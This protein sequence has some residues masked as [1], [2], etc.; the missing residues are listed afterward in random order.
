MSSRTILL[1]GVTGFLGKV[2]LEELMR[3][4]EEIGLDRVYAVIRPR[5]SV[6]A[7]RRFHREVERSPCFARLPAGWARLVT[8][9]EGSLGTPGLS[10]APEMRDELTERVT[11]AL[12][13]AATVS[14]GLPVAEAAQANVA[15]TL[16]L[17]E[18]AKQCRC[19]ERL[20][21]VSTAYVTPHTGDR[22]PVAPQPVPLPEP[23]DVLYEGICNGTASEEALLSA[24]GLPN[25]YTLTKLLAEHLTLARRGRVPLT[26]L[27]PSI[28]SASWRLPFPGWID[29]ATGFGAFVVQLGLGRMRA[30][31]GRAGAR[32]DLIPVDEVAHAVIAACDDGPAPV[33]IRQVVAGIDRSPTLWQC[34]EGIRD[35]FRLH[36]VDRRPT[37]RYLGPRG[38]GFAIAEA[39]HHRLATR[40]RGRRSP[41]ARRAAGQARARL[42]SLNRMFP[43]FTTNSFAFTEPT[44]LPGDFDPQTYVTRVCRGVHRHLLDG[45]EREWPLAGR[46]HPGHGGDFRWSLTRDRGNAWIRMASWVVTKVLRRSIERVTVDIPSFEAAIRAAPPGSALAVLPNHR[47]Y[48]D[49]VLCSYLCFARPDLGIP[50]PHIAA[51]LEFGKIPLL[52]R[53]LRAMHAFYLRRGIG[54]EDPDLTRRVHELVRDG[55]TLEFFI[56]GQRSRSRAFLEPKRGLLRCLQA[57]GRT[58]TL[59]PVA[60]SYDRVPEERAFAQELAGRPKP[61]MRLGDLLQWTWRAWRGRIDLGRVHIACGAPVILSAECDVHEVSREVIE[62][63]RQATVATTYHVEA[64]IARY[65]VDGLDARDLQ[66]AIEAMGGRVLPSHL[67]PTPDLDPLIAA[68]FRHQF[69]HHFERNGTVDGQLATIQHALFGPADNGN[70]ADPALLGP[71]A[72]SRDSRA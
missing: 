37:L 26:I 36:P 41:A 63:L 72:E 42:K 14:F 62:R 1:T 15:T 46:A 61:K 32:L 33:R 22:T 27:R 55:R 3:R 5:G 57:S 20:V 7:E 18:L 11:H 9:V 31:I 13:T 43:Y 49:F 35:F 71:P 60:F 58:C 2:V 59:L 51:T 24:T 21:F 68:T 66:R 28:I 25:T 19:L 4:R 64:Y 16:N 29:S 56:E 47:S 65:P 50:I 45:D 10:L 17:L 12:H 39:L 34:W 30:V 54:R 23:A 44:P 40:T 67:K 6:S 53:I 48:L 8:V 69:A 52:G 70:G 38:L